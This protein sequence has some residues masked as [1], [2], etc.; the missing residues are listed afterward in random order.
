MQVQI[1]Q[2]R[3][4]DAM[5]E[6]SEDILRKCVHCGMCLATCPSYLL[7]G[8]ELDSP[9]GRIYQIKGMIEAEAP[10]PPSLTKHMDRCLSCLSCVSTCPS[11]VEYGKL[12]D[13]AR[14]EINTKGKRIWHDK[15]LRKLIATIL[16]NR[17]ILRVALRMAMLVRPLK[18]LMPK[19]I[20][21]ML[22]L[23]PAKL[24][25]AAIHKDK[26]YA[27]QGETIARIGLLPGCVQQVL[28][29]EAISAAIEFLTRHGVEVTLT[30]ADAC[31]GALVQH[32]GY[33]AKARKQAKKTLDGWKLAM[34]ANRFDAIVH[35][36]SGCGTQVKDYPHLF[37]NDASHTNAAT[38]ANLA[39]DISE[40]VY[41]FAEKLPI[42]NVKLP[43]LRI[44][45]HSACSLR[46]G[47]RITMEP[48]EILKA[49]GLSIAEPKESHICCGSAGT[50]NIFQS[51]LAE[52][53]KN[54][55]V[56]NI[57]ATSPD[58]IVTGNLGCQQQ[59]QKATGIPMIHTIELLNWATGGT[60]PKSLQNI[61]N[62]N[63]T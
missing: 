51:D 44:T 41:L 8:D 47:Q 12:A 54:R 43:P 55:K 25:K 30:N 5:L 53:L 17:Q 61:A 32:M 52:Q 21:A 2:D 35:L 34:T 18:S 56:K 28:A 27:A 36:A 46:H 11:G 16:P 22:G 10:P 49:T 50:Y 29:P 9:R 7:L 62:I 26:T 33:A 39:K 3:L 63:K 45:Y 15:A 1:P 38:V 59:L 60:C 57:M 4:P 13:F 20:K 40:F 6:M 58:V 48:L 14:E 19:P 37:Q 24:P 23:L 31:C 42:R